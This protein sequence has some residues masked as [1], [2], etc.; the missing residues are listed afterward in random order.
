MSDETILSSVVVQSLAGK[1][2]QDYLSSRFRYHS[3]DDWS[4]IIRRGKVTVNGK[5]SLPETVLV[6]GDKVAYTAIL[7]EP[8]VERNIT[9]I[10][11]EE[12]FIVASKPG[13]L[14]S[15]ADGN[16]I[17]NTFVYILNEMLRPR[18]YAVPVKLVHRLDRETSGLMVAAIDP[19][20][21]R[22]LA[23]QFEAGEVKKEYIA[24][25]RG[26][27][28]G[29]FFEVSGVITR[30][31]DSS[32]SIRRKLEPDRASA[33]GKSV[34]RFEV[35]ERCGNYTILRC[36]PLT[37]R[38]NQIRVHLAHAGYPIAGDKLYGRTDAEFLEFVNSVRS[39]NYDPLPWQDAPRQ[40]LH[41]NRLEFL[42]PFNKSTL[43]FEA[44]VPDDM[45]AWKNTA[46]CC[47]KEHSI[48]RR[49]L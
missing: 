39:G 32:I 37:G 27:A 23:R 28:A 43:R 26:R 14:P 10:H 30:D 35:I 40:L 48:F 13:N 20:A 5:E 7:K 24:V 25:A 47:L 2:L 29:D 12:S 33:C 21:H 4:S 16:Y 42:H 41:A 49:V 38:T 22:D 6:K 1:S 11:E 15:H 36:I 17:K 31:M 34:T 3:R 8:P 46:D 9:I 18:G 44:P 45:L 19:A